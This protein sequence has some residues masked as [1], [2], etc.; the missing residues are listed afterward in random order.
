MTVFFK[1][2][3]KCRGDLQGVRDEFGGYL[4]CWHCGKF[5]VSSGQ[6]VPY[7]KEPMVVLEGQYSAR[8]RG[9]GNP[10]MTPD[11]YGKNL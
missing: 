4:F 9:G 1:A 8:R 11:N 2:C 7:K 3:P 5:I 10:R 6:E